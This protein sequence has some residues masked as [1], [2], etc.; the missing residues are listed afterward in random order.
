LTGDPIGAAYVGRVV[1]GQHTG[2]PVWA[3]LYPNRHGL[4]Y[5]VPS[6]ASSP[7]ET[8]LAPNPDGAGALQCVSVE[9]HDIQLD[10]H[11]D[12]LMESQLEVFVHRFLTTEFGEGPDWLLRS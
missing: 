11:V 9:F 12:Y 5:V 4:R 3:V 2:M 1:H 10:A 7:R 6:P 8:L